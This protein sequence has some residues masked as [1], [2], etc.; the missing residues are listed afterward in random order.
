MSV[1]NEKTGQEFNVAR[2]VP[3][4]AKAITETKV[5]QEPIQAKNEE[6]AKEKAKSVKKTGI[7]PGKG[8]FETF[9]TN[10]A[11]AGKSAFISEAVKRFFKLTEVLF[12]ENER[13][14][15]FPHAIGE[16]F[17]RHTVMRR[18]P[19]VNLFIDVFDANTPKDEINRIKAHMDAIGKKYTYIL[20][21]D[22]AYDEKGFMSDAFLK[23]VFETR[24]KP[25][26]PKLLKEPVNV[27]VAMERPTFVQ[28]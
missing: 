27:P 21:G 22:A 7:K 23:L 13:S 18:Y 20:G 26:D 1:K 9:T 8:V 4:V 24:L 28:G 16:K 5:K 14:W 25:V 17:K 10:E 2:V 12:N 6:I 19:Q 3:P 11:E 15:N